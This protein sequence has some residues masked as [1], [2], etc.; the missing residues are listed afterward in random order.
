MKLFDMPAVSESQSA[1]RGGRVFRKATDMVPK[2]A[3]DYSRARKWAPNA[4]FNNLETFSPSEVE[5]HGVLPQEDLWA[6]YEKY[7]QLWLDKM[8][9]SKKLQDE[10]RE[11][12]LWGIFGS[13]QKDWETPV[14]PF[15]K[16]CEGGRLWDVDDNEYI[17]LQF[18]DTPSMFGH[19]AENPAIKAAAES[20]LTTGID[21]MMGTADQADTAKEL[22]KHFKLPVWMHA[23]T[24]SDSN[25]YLLS[26]ARCVTG[27]PNIAIPNF[28]YH[29]TIDETQKMM[30]EP[31][32]I[33]RY[34]E[35]P[36]YYGEV[37][38][39]TKIFTWNDLESLEEC[40]KDGTR[41]THSATPGTAPAASRISSTICGPAVRR[42]PRASQVPCSA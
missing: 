4:D 8:P 28:T 31:G 32:V 42:F 37:D 36:Q 40:L 11:N 30:P 2:T 12:M 7:L 41:P 5:K 1:S 33:S 10:G 26:I 18:G 19:G 35:M 14:L 13:Y 6:L 29:G 27:R 9:T 24:A 21:P 23:L 3:F 25:R 22:Q 17:D 20:L 34:H 16:H 39:G 38:Q 15:S